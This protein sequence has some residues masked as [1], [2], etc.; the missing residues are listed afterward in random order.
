MIHE[1][2]NHQDLE[3]PR[4]VGRTVGLAIGLVFY[5]VLTVLLSFLVAFLSTV[6]TA[7]AYAHG[8]IPGWLVELI[9]VAL[10]ALTAVGLVMLYRRMTRKR[11][12]AY[13][14][15]AALVTVGLSL[16]LL[17]GVFV[18]PVAAPN[19]TTIK[20]S[21]MLDIGDGN[22]LAVYSYGPKQLPAG[23]SPIVFIVGGPGGSINDASAAFL[24]Q[25]ATT[26]DVPV[27]AYD[28]LGGGSHSS[29]P[30]NWVGS[31]TIDQEV[32]RAERVVDMVRDQYHTD[33]VALLAHSYGGSVAP[34]LIVK[35]PNKIASY[36][37]LDVAPLYTLMA[38]TPE[39]L[40]Q[41]QTSNEASPGEGQF[42]FGQLV[43]KVGPFGTARIFTSMG[44]GFLS[45]Q[46]FGFGTGEEN[47][48]I[49]QGA[50]P[51]GLSCTTANFPKGATQVN[52]EVNY[53]VNKSL[54]VSENYIPKLKE[55][56]RGIPVL[57]IGAE[58]TEKPDF[59]DFLPYFSDIR[60]VVAKKSPHAAWRS[61]TGLQTLLTT[62][63]KFLNNPASVTSTH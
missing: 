14:L 27:I 19:T 29:H 7:S 35:S 23:K 42:D 25:L 16:A 41:Q 60:T 28:P 30:A 6:L 11:S 38:N 43:S 26:A 34:R 31:Y 51:V 58:C 13:R 12:G 39:E 52:Q 47:S 44:A 18:V 4:G 55:A 54:D 21:S 50:V 17:V 3:R 24:E 48:Q 22:K 9:A 63:P 61:T 53:Y 57:I 37:G 49:L 62:I 36:V 10:G 59:S 1:H 46:A 5:V 2:P 40:K 33:K 20:P 45:G 15:G 32:Q 8:Q 56:S